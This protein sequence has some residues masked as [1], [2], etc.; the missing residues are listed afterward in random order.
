MNTRDGAKAI[1]MVSTETNDPLQFPHQLVMIDIWK[2][3]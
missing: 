2:A 3:A 1:A